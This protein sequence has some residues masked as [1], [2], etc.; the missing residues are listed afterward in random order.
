MPD[1]LAKIS[2]EQLSALVIRHCTRWLQAGGN[3][4]RDRVAESAT[5]ADV[6]ADDDTKAVLKLMLEK[7]EVLEDFIRT[8]KGGAGGSDTR[9]EECTWCAKAKQVVPST[10]HDGIARWW[11]LG[12]GARWPIAGRWMCRTRTH[13]IRSLYAKCT[14]RVRT[15]VGMC[16]QRWWRCTA[17]RAVLRDGGD[18][19]AFDVSAYSFTVGGA[20]EE[21]PDDGM[22]AELAGIVER[23]GGMAASAGLSLQHFDVEDV[24][25]PP[26]SGGAPSFHAVS[27]FFA[28]A[29]ASGGE[30]TIGGVDETHAG[31]VTDEEEDLWYYCPHTGKKERAVRCA[32]GGYYFMDSHTGAQQ[33]VARDAVTGEFSVGVEDFIN[34]G[35]NFGAF[36][37]PSDSSDGVHGESGSAAVPAVRAATTSSAMVGRAIDTLPP[38]TLQAVLQVFHE[39][40]E[41]DTSSGGGAFTSDDT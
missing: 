25:M 20:V 31:M 15:L 30:L 14:R 26:A 1:E 22:A 6:S 28:L 23:L 24:E 40:G 29:P 16:S 33:H 3:A 9:S 5:L 37:V 38:D 21:L 41:L 39:T 8:Q 13:Y 4:E 36:A 12:S 27:D 10:T 17:R 34:N 19:E 32:G 2:F 35:V 18:T 7:I 11:A